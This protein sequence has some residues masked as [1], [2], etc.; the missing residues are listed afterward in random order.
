MLEWDDYKDPVD[1][2]EIK[3]T[4]S[5]IGIN[6]PDDFIECVKIHHG[7]DPTPQDFDFISNFHGSLV[8]TCLGRMLSLKDSENTLLDSYQNLTIHNTLPVKVVPFA[9]D[10]GGDYIC[11]DYR[12]TKTNPSVV[13]WEHEAYPPEK[14]ISYLAPTFTDFLK[15][16]K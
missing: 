16:L 7:A 10:G 6:F 15:M 5:A 3:K 13:Y 12:E 14:A 8:E 9:V 11:F 2:N 4:E 1:Y